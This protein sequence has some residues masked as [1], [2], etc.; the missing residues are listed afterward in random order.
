MVVKLTSSPNSKLSWLWWG[1]VNCLGWFSSY[2][3]PL[4]WLSQ[5]L[6]L[7]W[8]TRSSWKTQWSWLGLAS[9]APGLL[10]LPWFPSFLEQLQVG[11]LLRESLPGWS[12]V[13]GTPLL[14]ALPLLLGKLLFGVLDI[15]FSIWFMLATGAWVGL[16]TLLAWPRR[17]QWSQLRPFGLWLWWGGLPI[18]LA[19]LISIWIPVLQPKRLLFIWPAWYLWLAH[20]ADSTWLSTQSWLGK[21]PPN[22]KTGLAGGLI[23]LLLLINAVGTGAYYTQPVLQRENWRG[24]V[25]QLAQ[26]YPPNRTVV[27]FSF[28]APFAPWEWYAQQT[29][30]TLSVGTL[31]TSA[32]QHTNTS[33]LKK[34]IEYDYVVTFDYLRD[35]TDPNRIITQ[36]LIEFGFAEKASYDYAQL[37]FVRVW[38]RPTTVLSETR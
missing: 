31:A 17:W 27:V 3:F 22:F 1:V 9:C 19:F 7:A 34:I 16:V 13:V 21:H 23:G 20:L 11:G 24:L 35:L 5:V 10:F 12:A 32:D 14:K 6:W 4:A 15:Q 18:V 33:N 25:T 29:F 37:G 8:S 30:P 36:N 28:P 26:D 38:A 2:L